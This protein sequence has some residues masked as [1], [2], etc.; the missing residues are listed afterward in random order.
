[1]YGNCCL[2]SNAQCSGLPAGSCCNG[3]CR[4]NGTCP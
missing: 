1:V 4:G 2:P 3:N